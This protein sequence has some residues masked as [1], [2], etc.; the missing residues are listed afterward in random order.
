MNSHR[1]QGRWIFAGIAIVAALLFAGTASHAAA[2]AFKKGDKV[3]AQVG[4]DWKSGTVTEILGGGRM[5]KVHLDDADAP[6][7]L[8]EAARE[9]FATRPFP[10]DRVRAAKAS[11]ANTDT[12]AAEEGPAATPTKKAPAPATNENPVRKWSDRSGKFSVDARFYNLKGDRVAL[13]KADGKLLEVPLS[14]LSDDDAKYVREQTEPIDE[15]PFAAVPGTVASASSDAPLGLPS[16]DEP[17]GGPSAPSAVKKANWREVRQVR[18]QTFKKWSFKPSA[19]ESKPRATNTANVEVEL[20][21]IPGSDKFFEKVLGVY[22]A[23]DSSRAIVSRQKGAVGLNEQ[24]YLELVDVAQN[25]SLGLTKLP[26]KT[27]LLDLSPSE[28]LVMYRSDGDGFGNGNVLTI[29]R[30]DGGQL[31]PVKQWAPYDQEKWEP[32]RDIDK[33]W[34]LGDGRVMTANQHAEALVVWDVDA[35]KALLNIPIGRGMQLQVALSPDGKLLAIAMRE[36]VAI[37]DV[38]AGQH[39]ATIPTGKTRYTTLAIR[40]DN[41]RLAGLS[42]EGAVVWDLTSGEKTQDMFSTAMHWN[43]ELNWAGDLLLVGN[44]NLFDVGRRILLWEYQGLPNMGKA[45]TMHAGRLWVVPSLQRESAARLVSMAMPHAA[46]LEE[47]SKLPPAEALLC[48]K[49]GDKVAIEVDIDPGVVLTDDIQASLM[50]KI[51]GQ[52]EQGGDGKVVMLNPGRAQGDLIREAL[53]KSLEAA[54]LE[55]VDHADLV[56]KAVCKPQP[57][58]TIRIN[59]DNRWP[60]RESD[61]VERA[62]TPHA[63]FLEMKLKGETLWKRGYVAQPH[64]TIW[65]NEGETLDQALE[66][67]TKPNLTIFTNAKFSA[68]VAR[69][70]KAT[71]NGAYGVSQFSTGGLVDG[72]SDSGSAGGV[73]E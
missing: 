48:V 44:Q 10:I 63:S 56:V 20:G 46:A 60:R 24:E 64:M 71:A 39:V 55:V 41:A 54:G 65:L 45:T 33:A 66:R 17:A 27:K 2:A 13:V 4:G 16:A 40:D 14:K 69:P 12:P 67:M 8:P 52:N 37:I 18:P 3:E 21:D 59:T 50:A 31:S 25:K 23:D 72:K 61:I 30:V 47:A 22:V 58:Q 1:F 38:A 26:A 28:G 57:Q 19:E 7:G 34:F 35:A 51:Q 70:G 53:A 6:S 11:A 68:Y 36:G 5:V 62:V 49:P 42:D 32:S 43:S 29:A 9:R 73:F 15:N